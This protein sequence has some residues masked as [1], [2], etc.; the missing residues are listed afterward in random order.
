LTLEYPHL[1]EDTLG[2]HEIDFTEDPACCR[3]ADLVIIAVKGTVTANLSEQIK[4]HLA[5][6]AILLTLQNGVSHGGTLKKSFPDH[7]VLAGM[8]TFNVIEIN[9]HT[10]RLTTPGEIYL[11]KSSLSPSLLDFFADS[12]LLVRE[13]TDIEGLLWSKLLLN[14]INPLNALSGQSLKHNLEDHHF[15]LRWAACMREGLAVLKA[16]GI[17]P[18][19]VTPL[20]PRFLPFMVSLP[21]WIYLAL[22]KKMVDMDPTARSSMAQDIAKGQSTEIDYLTGELLQ[23]A[24]RFNVATPV[25]KQIYTE[26]NHIDNKIGDT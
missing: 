11:Q 3:D 22:A 26:I 21:N 7:R 18:V 17:K 9:S 10:F 25:N 1:P 20:P 16:A 2:P 6:K 4:P 5:S 12:K 15:R 8:V 14:L 19:K 23:L 24:R 13:S